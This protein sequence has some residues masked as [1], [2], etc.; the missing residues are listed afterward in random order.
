MFD[1]GEIEVDGEHVHGNETNLGVLRQ[2]V[3]M[4]FQ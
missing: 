3:G 1:E 4:V 2:K